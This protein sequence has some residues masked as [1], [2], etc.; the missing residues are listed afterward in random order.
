LKKSQYKSF[1]TAVGPGSCKYI[2]E[3]EETQDFH[4]TK[5]PPHQV[6]KMGDKNDIAQHQNSNI[7]GNSFGSKVF[8]KVV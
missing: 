7:K 2:G 4:Q 3:I 8:W 1:F 6:K 5:S